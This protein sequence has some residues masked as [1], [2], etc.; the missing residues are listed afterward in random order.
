MLDHADGG[1]V[2]G[3]VCGIVWMNGSIGIQP[4]KLDCDYLRGKENQC[5]DDRHSKCDSGD[6]SRCV[7]ELLLLAHTEWKTKT[8]KRWK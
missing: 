8:E 5:K 2:C 7:L 4:D 3:R 1:K 6:C